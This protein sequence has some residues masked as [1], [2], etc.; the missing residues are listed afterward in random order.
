MIGNNRGKTN[1]PEYSQ[2]PSTVDSSTLSFISATFDNDRCTD[3][4][5]CVDG[6]RA[7]GALADYCLQLNVGKTR[8]RQSIA[9]ALPV[10]LLSNYSRT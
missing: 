4:Q 10:H 3:P 5:F 8:T 1:V 7:H 6:K 9:Y 2:R